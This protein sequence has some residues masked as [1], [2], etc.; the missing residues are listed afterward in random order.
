MLPLV[1]IS[2]LS[3]AD[4]YLLAGAVGSDMLGIGIVLAA[5]MSLLRKRVERFAA[6]P[7]SNNINSIEGPKVVSATATAFRRDC[8][9]CCTKDCACCPGDKCGCAKRRASGLNKVTNV[10]QRRKCCDCCTSECGC[11]ADKCKCGEKRKGMTSF[12]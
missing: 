1:L 7:C 9:A 3:H 2:S 8:C 5:A 12:P 11:C 10:V 4:G 6:E